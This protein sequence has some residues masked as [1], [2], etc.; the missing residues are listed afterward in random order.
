VHVAA[1]LRLP[2]AAD[3]A[4]AAALLAGALALPGLAELE[5]D[6]VLPSDL[7]A[8]MARSRPDATARTLRRPGQRSEP[9]CAWCLSSRAAAWAHK[10]TW[11]ILGAVW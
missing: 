4:G 7:G 6:G 9:C 5:L 11:L 2:E 8:A 10:G 1:R 3:A